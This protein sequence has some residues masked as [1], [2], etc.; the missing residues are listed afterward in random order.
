MK[1]ITERKDLQGK[2]VIV[3][4]SCNVPIAN[5]QVV[6]DFRLKSMLPTLLWLRQAGAR[7]IVIAHIGRA[8]DET[9]KPVHEAFAKHLPLEWGGDIFGDAFKVSR[10]A[11]QDGDI[12]LAE[13]IRQDAREAENNEAMAEYLAS[14]ADIYV[15]EAFDNIHRLHTSMVALPKLLP[16]Y[17]GL[18]FQTEVSKVAKAMAPEHPSLFI[19]GGAKFET[20][21]PLIEKYLATYDFVFVGGALAHDILK[22]D[23]YEVGQSLVSPVSLE[24]H[25][26]LQ[27]KKLLRPVDVVIERGGEQLSVLV[28]DVTTEDVILDMGE[29]T[30]TMLTPYIKNAKTILWNGPLG[31][32]EVGSGGSTEAVAQLI[33]ASNAFSVLGGGDTVAA[34]ESLGL[35]QE[36]G[37]VST[38]GGAMLTYLENGTTPA[39]EAFDEHET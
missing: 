29:R 14:L 32:Y 8:A 23:G 3:R 28:K 11:M 33:A 22:A 6:N 21:I 27:N 26:M 36:F 37:H 15:N 30:V 12:M 2:Y 9:L 35:N 1:V 7:I 31:K 20:K 10:E 34:V 24:G 25:P 17:I 16:S 13:N 18:N 39:L 4:A 19:I 38:G 5:G